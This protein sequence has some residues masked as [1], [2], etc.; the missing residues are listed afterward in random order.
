M[1]ILKYLEYPYLQI[2]SVD[3]T[4]V[5]IDWICTRSGLVLQPETI[6]KTGKQNIPHED[7]TTKYTVRQQNTPYEDG[8]SK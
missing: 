6:T 5:D 1:T 8:K 2:C 7:G 4:K 3:D